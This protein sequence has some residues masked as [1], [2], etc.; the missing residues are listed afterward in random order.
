MKFSLP[1]LALLVGAFLPFAGC[2]IDSAASANQ[3]AAGTVDF[4]LPAALRSQVKGVADSLRIELRQG[5]RYRF[6]SCALDSTV[7]VSDLESG[8]WQIEVG[9]YSADGAL[10]Y[11]GASTV[12]V[13]PGKL[14]HASVTLRPAKGDVDIS[15]HLEDGQ[16]QDTLRP[17]ELWGTWNFNNWTSTAQKPFPF[18]FTLDSTGWL[19]GWNGN[20]SFSGTWGVVDGQLVFPRYR[21]QLD[22]F[23]SWGAGNLIQSLSPYTWTYYPSEQIL[24]AYSA[25][26]SFGFKMS[27]VQPS[28]PNNPD[29][30]IGNWLLLFVD[31]ASQT[32][33]PRA[34][35]A[36][37]DSDIVVGYDGCNDFSG[38]WTAN[39]N[40][41]SVRVLKA[42]KR[43]CAGVPG[44]N[45]LQTLLKTSTS[46][47]FDGQYLSLRD[48]AGFFT[49]NF[50]RI[51]Q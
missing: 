4:S 31:S 34:T 11:F 46:W 13:T 8:A 27:R 7:H 12:Q 14:A 24:S 3:G 25:I 50:E 1:L 16:Y 10:H 28:I 19:V 22:T 37:H 41:L 39:Q 20:D 6:A 40:R 30:L 5:S 49:G 26:D 47:V 43:N 35:V 2:Q 44:V 21:S 17:R 51:P 33:A 29:Q 48:S 42:T 18:S 23:D 38:I 15:I 9:L 45:G 32:P 36:F